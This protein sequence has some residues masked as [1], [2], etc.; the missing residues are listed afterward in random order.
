MKHLDIRGVAPQDKFRHMNLYFLGLV[1]PLK[2]RGREEE[3]REEEM[4][5]GRGSPLMLLMFDWGKKGR[6]K[7]EKKLQNP[8]SPFCNDP[9]I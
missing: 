9:N 8:T 6:G 7:R 4:K 1:W 2:E 5:R 3:E